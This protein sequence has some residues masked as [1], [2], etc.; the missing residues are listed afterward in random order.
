MARKSW[1][2]SQLLLLWA[3][4]TSTPAEPVALVEEP[5]IYQYPKDSLWRGHPLRPDHPDYINNAYPNYSD[6]IF[7][8]LQSQEDFNYPYGK[9]EE[10]VQF[11][12]YQLES[13]R[14][15]RIRYLMGLNIPMRPSAM[16]QKRYLNLSS[17]GLK[18]IPYELGRLQSLE[19]LL[20]KYNQI[21]SFSTSLY[22]CKALKRLD[23]SSNQLEE[24]PNSIYQLR[25]LENLS[26][27]D[28]KLKF[29]PAG[30]SQLR[31]LRSLD[32]SNSHRSMAGAY[33]NFRYLPAA[34]YRLPKLE[35]LLLQRLPLQQFALN[36]QQMKSLRVLS[37][38]GCYQLP[39]D[40][41]LKLLAQLPKLE[42]LD[43][44]F[45]GRRTLPKS[46]ERFKQLKVLIWQEENGVNEQAIKALKKI[47][48][49]TRIY[50]GAPGEKRPFLRANS[51]ETIIQ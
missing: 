16:A 11:F 9:S 39:L 31:E 1:L 26:L 4:Q 17:R 46:I 45:L 44:S 41:N 28:N 7:A 47:L 30:F 20:L 8:L 49:N 22:Q 40:N 18:E 27:R 23:L 37:I 33:N 25:K 48:P 21:R 6:S 35:K 50:W 43:I 29:L 19:E 3:C 5:T 34:V 24:L 10:E 42:V 2:L 13:K 36:V 51:I 14:R 12:L 32:L 38:A 15:A